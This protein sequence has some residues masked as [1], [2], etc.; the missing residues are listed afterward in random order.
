MDEVVSPDSLLMLPALLDRFGYRDLGALACVCT[1]FRNYLMHREDSWGVLCSA[2]ARELGLF[3]PASYAHGWQRYFWEHLMVLCKPLS[4]RPPL[5]LLWPQSPPADLTPRPFSTFF[6]LIPAVLHPP[7]P[8]PTLP[9]RPAIPPCSTPLTPSSICVLASLCL[10]FP[11]FLPRPPLLHAPPP[12]AHAQRSPLAPVLLLLRPLSTHAPQALPLLT[13]RL[14]AFLP[15]PVVAVETQVG[16][17]QARGPQPRHRVQDPGGRPLPPRAQGGGLWLCPAAP[18]APPAPQDRRGHQ[19]GGGRWLRDHGGG[20]RGAAG[21]WWC[22]WRD[23]A[24]CPGSRAAWP[25]CGG[26]RAQSPLPRWKA[27]ARLGGGRGRL[28]RKRPREG[29]ASPRSLWEQSRRRGK[30]GYGTPEAALNLPPSFCHLLVAVAL[31]LF[32]WLCLSCSPFPLAR[33][34]GVSLARQAD[35]ALVAPQ[36][37]VFGSRPASLTSAA[38]GWRLLGPGEEE[39]EEVQLE[40]HRKGGSA[41]LLAVQDSGTVT[42]YVPGVITGPR[43]QSDHGVK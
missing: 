33:M 27:S 34:C 21:G 5:V 22:W 12:L 29:E 17:Q 32:Y 10:P 6:S 2:M 28:G 9:Y 25:P 23:S 7:D 1:R 35:D 14:H 16:N 38:G 24:G 8:L 37:A 13:V 11:F 20:T 43:Q 30:G 39:E 4:S 36:T 19:P 31:A 41:R 3:R 40:V 18:P 26:G 15:L 42:M